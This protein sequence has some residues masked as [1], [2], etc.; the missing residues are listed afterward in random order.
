MY[1]G[2]ER[3]T[4]FCAFVLFPALGWEMESAKSFFVSVKDWAKDWARISWL[5]V[6]DVFASEWVLVSP[7]RPS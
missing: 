5:G 6:S 2:W 7:Q 4:F 1:P 3:E